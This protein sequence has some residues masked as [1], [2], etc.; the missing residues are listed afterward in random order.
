MKKT[1]EKSK[2]KNKEIKMVAFR[3][4]VKAKRQLNILAAEQDRTGQSILIEAVND[5]FRKYGKPPI[6]QEREEP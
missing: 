3:L 2:K 5:I 6:T 1:S 4:S